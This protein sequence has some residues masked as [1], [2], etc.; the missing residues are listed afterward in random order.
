MHVRGVKRR[1]HK[2]R[3]WWVGGLL[4]A[5]L[6]M[7]SS[8]I[9]APASADP[10][11]QTFT[12]TSLWHCTVIPWSVPGL[13]T[14]TCVVVSGQ[15][16]QSVVIVRNFSSIA[17]TIEA[18]NV[19]LWRQGGLVYDRNCLQST[20]NAGLERACFAPTV[21]CTVN[22]QA[23]SAIAINGFLDWRFSPTRSCP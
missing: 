9:A 6:F 16:T 15:V 13:S 23:Q 22:T 3:R 2:V 8:V 18:P 14:E 11:W 10:F 7:L 12:K 4:S 20:L 19:R 1:S 21:S 17:L 5:A